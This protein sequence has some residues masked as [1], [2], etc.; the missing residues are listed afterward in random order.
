[1]KRRREKTQGL[2]SS[3]NSWTIRG[4]RMRRERLDSAGTEGLTL[5][6]LLDK[7]TT[8]RAVVITF[9]AL[10]ELARVRFIKLLQAEGSGTLRED[11][12]ESAEERAQGGLIH[13]G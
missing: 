7:D 5:W 1:M 10:L 12:N 13:G 6:A 4:S 11:R 3:G 8:R 2:S 9:L